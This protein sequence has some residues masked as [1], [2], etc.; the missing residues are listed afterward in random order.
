MRNKHD[1]NEDLIA[2]TQAHLGK[3]PLPLPLENWPLIVTFDD[4]SQPETLHFVT[5]TDLSA[6]FGPGVMLQGLTL[7]IVK[8]PV[9]KGRI[10]S[11]LPWL[12]PAGSVRGLVAPPP[13]PLVSLG[14]FLSIDHWS[15]T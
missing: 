13:A 5:G 8:A 3:P 1:R 2:E 11:F 15:K 12:L 14:A 7:Q 9:T 4:I 10:N 6:W